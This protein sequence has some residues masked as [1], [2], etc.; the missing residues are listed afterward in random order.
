MA[1]IQKGQA[2]LWGVGNS[3]EVT[4]SG[5]ASILVDSGKATHKFKITPI[6]NESG[7]DV[8]LVATNQM[9]EMEMVFVPEGATGAFNEPFATITTSGFSASELNGDWI[10]VGDASVDLSHKAGKMTIKGRRYINNT[11]LS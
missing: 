2:V 11:N 7:M 1:E 5:Y 6:E 10:Y 9:V 8:T 3:G 4:V